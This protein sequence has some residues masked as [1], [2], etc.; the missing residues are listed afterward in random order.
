VLGGRYR[1]PS[2]RISA[3]VNKRE[4]MM[5]RTPSGASTEN[6]LPRPFTTST[7]RCVCFQYPHC[8][9]RPVR[10]SLRHAEMLALLALHPDGLTADRLAC[11]L[12]GDAGN[13]VTVRSEVHRL[14]A[15][16][17]PAAI[18]TQPYRLRVRVDADFLDLRA[19]LRAGRVPPPEVL[20]RGDL[21]PASDAPGVREERDHLE[22]AV[23]G[24]VLRRGDVDALWALAHTEAGAADPELA[25]HLRHLLPDADPRRDELGP[26]RAG[27]SRGSRCPSSGPDRPGAAGRVP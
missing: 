23:R 11:A 15:A 16:L 20:R 7:V 24:A 22:V 9:G 26:A 25:A 1:S 27:I 10:L 13:P 4:R 21:L 5:K 19:A 2:S 12:Y 18:S 8:D 3:S 14:R 17:G 6:P